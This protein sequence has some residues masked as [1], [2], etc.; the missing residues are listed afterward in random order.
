[1]VGRRIAEQHP[2][3]DRSDL[4]PPLAGELRRQAPIAIDGCNQCLDIDELGLQLNHQQRPARRMECE[5]VD[6]TSLAVDRERRLRGQEPARVREGTGDRFVH[7]RMARGDHPIEISASPSGDVLEADFER[8]SDAKQRVDRKAAHMAALDP[9]DG[10]AGYPGAQRHIGLTPSMP[11]TNRPEYRSQSKRIHRAMMASGALSAAYQAVA[12]GT[13]R[14]L[15]GWTLIKEGRG[16]TGCQLH[17]QHDN[18]DRSHSPRS[19]IGRPAGQ[20]RHCLPPAQERE[21][22]APGIGRPSGWTP[23]SARRPAREAGGRLR[24]WP[25]RDPWPAS[26]RSA[27]RRACRP[28]ARAAT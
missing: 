2:A 15:H 4:P 26:G 14:L 12:Q 22:A 24:R 25:A 23:S 3:A 18:Q 9:R 27:C 20:V 28:R 10:G 19:T 5:D 13:R 11:Q 17:P 6:D 16:R 1:M 21:E 8:G 7:R